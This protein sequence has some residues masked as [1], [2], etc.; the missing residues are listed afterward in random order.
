MSCLSASNSSISDD[1]LSDMVT[2]RSTRDV[3]IYSGRTAIGEEVNIGAVR[4][5]CFLALTGGVGGR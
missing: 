2:F 3:V 5:V 1:E 4:R